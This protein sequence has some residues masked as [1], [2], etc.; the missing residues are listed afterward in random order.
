VRAIENGTVEDELR[1]KC[2]CSAKSS[3][4]CKSANH[5]DA[6][7]G[8][9][10][11]HEA[12]G[13]VDVAIVNAEA[14]I[15]LAPREPKVGFVL[16]TAGCVAHHLSLTNYRL[17]RVSCGSGSFYASRARITRLS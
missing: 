14:M 12:K 10:A 6:L 17:Q 7:D 13:L 8:L 15:N 5:V 2:I 4:R 9:A 3:V 16:A 1:K 11:V